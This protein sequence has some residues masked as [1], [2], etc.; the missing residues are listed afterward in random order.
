MPPSPPTT[1]RAAR[2]AWSR[3]LAGLAL[4][5]GLVLP[6]PPPRAQLPRRPP[7]DHRERKLLKREIHDDKRDLDRLLVRLGRLDALRMSRWPEPRALS[8]F[9]AVVHEEML[10]EALE[11]RLELSPRVRGDADHQH[12]T[13][14]RRRTD[15]ITR[16]W[17]DLAGRYSGVD[18]K[19]RWDLLSELADLTRRELEEDVKLF[20]AMGGVLEP[21]PA[22]PELEG[23][24]GAGAAGGTPPPGGR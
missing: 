16:A 11:H 9:D 6:G 1:A 22:A 18:L 8:E 24:V 23:E 17:A 15:E 4:A 19:R 13:A 5:L 3:P 20:T 7:A 10:R 12:R 21:D 2:R 14:E